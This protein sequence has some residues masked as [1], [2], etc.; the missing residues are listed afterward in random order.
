MVTLIIRWSTCN[1]QLESQK[2]SIPTPAS[3]SAPSDAP[4]ST[5]TQTEPST[6]VD[7]NAYKVQAPSDIPRLYQ[8][9]CNASQKFSPFSNDSVTFQTSCN[10]DVAAISGDNTAMPYIPIIAYNLEACFSA[11]ERF[12][13]FLSEEGSCFGVA[14]HYDM[15]TMAASE[16]YG[17]CKILYDSSY[18]EWSDINNPNVVVG[19]MCKDSSCDDHW[20]SVQNPPS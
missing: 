1:V 15:A 9:P 10:I 5:S 13:S 7:L 8:P 6:T 20:G 19:L 12:N 11:C 17:N 2:T 14:F 4:T 3:A 16:E 18:L